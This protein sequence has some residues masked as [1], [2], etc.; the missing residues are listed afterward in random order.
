MQE[1]SETGYD[2][3]FNNSRGFNNSQPIL[4]IFYWSIEP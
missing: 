2:S 1:V 4:F 3:I